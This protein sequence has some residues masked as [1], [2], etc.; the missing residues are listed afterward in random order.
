M[1]RRPSSDEVRKAL[2]DYRMLAD[3]EI[4]VMLEE[5]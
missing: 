5:L 1:K 3:D 2:Q 4:E